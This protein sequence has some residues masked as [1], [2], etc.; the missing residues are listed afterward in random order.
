MRGRGGREGKRER[1]NWGRR[2]ERKKG[3]GGRIGVTMREKRRTYRVE[4]EEE[5]GTTLW[6]CGGES[7]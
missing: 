3:K 2:E 5:V 4:L 6:V 1:V 7:E